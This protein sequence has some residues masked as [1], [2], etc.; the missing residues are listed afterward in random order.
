VSHAWSRVEA[1]LGRVLPAAL[2]NL[3]PP[4]DERAIAALEAAL[5]VTL[6]ADF[7]ASLGVHNGTTWGEPWPV[8][9]EEL[10]DTDGIARATRQ[11][12]DSSVPEPE[13]DD[14]RV[15]AWQI[16][17]NDIWVSG[18]VRPTLDS[19]DR[20]FLGT[21]N[22]DVHWFL[23][24]DPPPGGTPGQVVRV[25]PECMQWD[26]LAPSWTGLLLRYAD[27]LDNSTVEVDPN[28]GPVPEWGTTIGERGT[29]PEWLRDVEARDPHAQ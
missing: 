26:V 20:I 21:M 14:P 4:A 29:R 15:W 9:L 24:L 16:D 19:P 27:A 1:A 7:R 25:D 2:T 22:G 28:L 17:E 13:W 18:P 3:A 12:R 6:P 8:P 11:W 5:S 23:D 10:Y